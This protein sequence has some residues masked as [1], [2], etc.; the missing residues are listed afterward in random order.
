MPTIWP[1]FTIELNKT[2]VFGESSVFT[3]TTEVLAVTV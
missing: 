3:S 1:G 2:T